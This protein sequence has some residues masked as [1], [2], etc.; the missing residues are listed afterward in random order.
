MGFWDSLFGG[1]GKSEKQDAGE[2]KILAKPFKVAMTFHPLRLSAHKR[3]SA[4]LIVKVTN[5]TPDPQLVSVDVLLPKNQMLGF[6]PTCINKAAEKKAGN[7]G[8]NQTAEVSIPVWA[9]NQT[10]AGS[11]SMMVTVFA[12][13][14]DYNKVLSYIKKPASLR[15]V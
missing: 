14:Q 13:Y 9:N 4:N 12:H 6:E 5:L 15:V 8:P 7:V 11:Y 3:N 1:E 10:K 2:T